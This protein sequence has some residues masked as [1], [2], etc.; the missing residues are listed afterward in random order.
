[1][2]LV[3][4]ILWRRETYGQCIFLDPWIVAVRLGCEELS[5]ISVLL[6]VAVVLCSVDCVHK[7]CGFHRASVVLSRWRV[8]VC[9]ARCMW[10]GV[11]RVVLVKGCFYLRCSFTSKYSGQYYERVSFTLLFAMGSSM[12]K[13]VVFDPKTRIVRKSLSLLFDD[14][15]VFCGSYYVARG[16]S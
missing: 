8:L 1:M 7:R 13:V 3:D 5:V 4:Y 14:V 9:V 12:E 6:V 10:S 16:L 2:Q 11:V 15:A